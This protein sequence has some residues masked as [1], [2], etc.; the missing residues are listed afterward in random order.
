[1]RET[2]RTHLEIIYIGTGNG[3]Q[4]QCLRIYIIYFYTDWTQRSRDASIRLAPCFPDGLEKKTNTSAP[5]NE[6]SFIN[7]LCTNVYIFFFGGGI[8]FS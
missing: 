1:M 6:K 4:E 8:F 7:G 2:L 3:E 5:G